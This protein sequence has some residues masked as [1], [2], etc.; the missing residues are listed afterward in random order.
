MVRA[1]VA[2]D[3]QCLMNFYLFV[4]RMT[5]KNYKSGRRGGSVVEF[6]GGAHCGRAC[7]SATTS[8]NLHIYCMQ[9]TQAQSRAGGRLSPK[10][11]A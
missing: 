8:P 10:S 6:I 5:C 11:G 1:T 2:N 7:D 9:G 3:G 4:Y